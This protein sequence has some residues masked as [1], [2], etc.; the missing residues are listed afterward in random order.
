MLNGE[1]YGPELIGVQGEQTVYCGRGSGD[2]V[3]T[4]VKNTNLNAVCN[5]VGRLVDGDFSRLAE[6]NALIAELVVSYVNAGPFVNGVIHQVQEAGYQVSS[7]AM[8]RVAGVLVNVGDKERTWVSQGH[9]LEVIAFAVA[10]SSSTHEGTASG[11]ELSVGGRG[12]QVALIL[13]TVKSAIDALSVVLGNALEVRLLTHDV[14]NIV[15]VLHEH[16]V[17]ANRE[18]FCY[19]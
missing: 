4:V 7:S 12:N 10:S 2:G 16:E 5:Q 8:R 18:H 14:L 19:D 6:H 9:P 15:G 13:H 17:A 11:V 1:G 3:L